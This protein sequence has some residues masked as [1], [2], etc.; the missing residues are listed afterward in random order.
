MASLTFLQGL[1]V[2]TELSSG[3]GPSN[4]CR[5]NP[6]EG[7]AGCAT[8]FKPMKIDL[9]VAETPCRPFSS[10]EVPCGIKNRP[11]SLPETGAKKALEPG[12]KGE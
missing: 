9:G 1:A 10:L 2:G 5:P 4:F 8:L 3:A 12:T 11:E 7:L 6:F